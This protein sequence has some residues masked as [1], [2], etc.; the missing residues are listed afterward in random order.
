MNEHLNTDIKDLKSKRTIR[1]FVL[2]QGRLT[3]GQEQALKNLWPTFGIE[4]N[5]N[6]VISF[7]TNKNVV[8]EIG[9]GMGAS[10]IEMAKNAPNTSFLGIEV[11][12]PGIGSCLMA[13][14]ENQLP[15]LKVMCHDA[16]EVLQNMITND[17]LNKV[18]I[19]FPDPWHK[20]KH[21]KRRII[22]P[23][24][25]ELIRQKLKPG[26]ILHLATDWQHYAEH[27]LEVLTQAKGF[28][29]LSITNDY[30]PRPEERPITK[31]EKRGKNLGHGVWDLQFM[32]K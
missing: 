32:K 26:G 12:K 11:H 10:L 6:S 15:N 30:I 8:L 9:F 4:Y 7:E 19:F 27:M 16:V 22:Q 20:A 18:Q 1:S 14:E 28:K 31:F 17:S 24:F 21:N 25:V 5:P 13:I 29:N 3:K 2:R 23:N